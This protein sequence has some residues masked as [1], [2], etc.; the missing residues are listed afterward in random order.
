MPH[1]IRMWHYKLLVWLGSSR[2]FFFILRYFVSSKNVRHLLM[3]TMCASNI[4]F[5]LLLFRKFNFDKWREMKRKCDVYTMGFKCI[6]VSEVFKSK[7][8]VHKTLSGWKKKIEV[9]DHLH[10]KMW[11]LNGNC[12]L[13]KCSLGQHFPYQ[14]TWL[15]GKLKKKKKKICFFINSM[16]E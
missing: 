5:F 10:M 12:Y 11:Q 2:C 16:V 14:N 8:K 6:D 3:C 4:V 1:Q 7:I 13:F 15:F 9:R